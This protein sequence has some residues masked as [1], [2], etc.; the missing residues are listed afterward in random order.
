MKKTIS[1]YYEQLFKNNLDNLHEMD[2][3]REKYK[4]SQFVQYKIFNLNNHINIKEIEL[5][6]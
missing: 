3:F 4:L 5:I 1:E 6:N 2:H